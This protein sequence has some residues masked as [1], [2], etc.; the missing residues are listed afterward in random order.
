MRK[1]I[2]KLGMILGLKGLLSVLSV[3][4]V[5]LA[6]VSYTAD[7]VITPTAQLIEGVTSETWTIYVNEVDQYRYLPDGS[8][9]PAGSSK[10][11][12]G[13]STYAF[14]VTADSDKVC[15][16]QIELTSAVDSGKFSKF[17]ITVEKWNSTSSAWESETLYSAATGSAA[18]PYIDGLSAGPV[19]AGYVH[20]ST[21]ATEYYLVVVQ[22]SYDL[23][24]TTDLI[25]VTFQYTPLPQDSF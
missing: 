8:G 7:V 11:A 9:T 13:T 23:V 16:V 14:T 22:Y 19:D 2:K 6:L 15:A 1:A 20:Q 3:T 12:D 18:K 24:D 10:P 17:Q 21:G 25:T 5:V 4:T